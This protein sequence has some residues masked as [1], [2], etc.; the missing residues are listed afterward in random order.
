MNILKNYVIKLNLFEEF[1]MFHNTT[2]SSD[3]YAFHNNS[4]FLYLPDF[5]ELFLKIMAT[6]EDS[7]CF[8]IFRLV[9][10]ENLDVKRVPLCC[11]TGTHLQNN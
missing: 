5:E 10:M 3:D 1:H 2:D 11:F 6:C 9:S 8:L 4:K 7:K